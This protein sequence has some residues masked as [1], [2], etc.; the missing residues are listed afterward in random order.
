MSTDDFP[1]RPRASGCSTTPGLLADD[2]GGSTGARVCAPQNSIED[3][4][5]RP[6]GQGERPSQ[7]SRTF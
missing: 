6:E 1:P 5:I 3:R 7:S 4:N 2:T